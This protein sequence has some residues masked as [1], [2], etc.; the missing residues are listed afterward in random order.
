MYRISAN[1]HDHRRLRKLQSHAFSE[2][3]LAAQESLM[4]SHPLLFVKKLKEQ[5]QKPTK[6]LV[7]LNQ[8]YNFTTFDLI[9]DLAFGEP[10]GLTEQG[11]PNE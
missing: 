11:A 1:G 10:F 6:G 8:W 9:G 3:A 7:A 4:Q 2:K 5:C